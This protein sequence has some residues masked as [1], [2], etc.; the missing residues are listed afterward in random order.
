[1]R[2]IQKDW[3][4]DTVFSIRRAGSHDRRAFCGDRGLFTAITEKPTLRKALS[5]ATKTRT[6]FS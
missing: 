2:N 1:M 3:S 5:V 6:P 4:G